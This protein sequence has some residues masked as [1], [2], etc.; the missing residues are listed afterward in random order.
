[1]K[2]ALARVT[3]FGLSVTSKRSVGSSLHHLLQVVQFWV[4]LDIGTSGELFGLFTV[5]CISPSLPHKW[6]GYICKPV[7][8][9]YFC[10]ILVFRNAI[11]I[12]SYWSYISP[13]Y[14]QLLFLIIC[15]LFGASCA[16]NHVIHEWRFSVLIA[17]ALRCF[18]SLFW[19]T[20]LASG[21]DKGC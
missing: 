6:R 11:N 16:N 1:M 19:L 12:S 14:S 7:F 21:P 20:T 15:I 18:L 3:L 5:L 17:L 4:S 10:L 2:P 9:Y 8:K 13:I